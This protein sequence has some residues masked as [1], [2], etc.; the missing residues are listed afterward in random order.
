MNYDEVFYI[1]YSKV[2]NNIPDPGTAQEKV[3]NKFV[4]L[5]A[6]F[7][8]AGWENDLLFTLI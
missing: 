6:N 8:K 3:V 1:F 4:K 7:A 2:M 5:V